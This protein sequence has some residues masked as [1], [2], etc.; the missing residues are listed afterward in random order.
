MQ[1][2]GR[3]RARLRT[4][5]NELPSRYPKKETERVSNERPIGPI[6]L[7]Q[8][9]TASTFPSD[10]RRAYLVPRTKTAVAIPQPHTSHID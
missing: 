3:Q 4:Q 1:E 10:H 2:M 6:D 5:P 9:G 7:I 8:S